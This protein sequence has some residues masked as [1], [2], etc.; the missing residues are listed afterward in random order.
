DVMLT[1]HDITHD[2]YK[3]E[4]EEKLNKNGCVM[5][6]LLQKAGLASNAEYKVEKMHSEFIKK[7]GVQPGDQR[8]EC[9]D[10]CINESKDLTE[11]CVK[12][13]NLSACVIKFEHRHKHENDH[14]HDHEHENESAK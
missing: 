12:A 7:T 8:L 9:L 2:R 5:Q 11:K 13:F 14:E 6:C 10:T 4:S 1:V 3:S